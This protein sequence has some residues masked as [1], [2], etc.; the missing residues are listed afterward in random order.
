M[1]EIMAFENDS[2]LKHCQYK[3]R[4]KDF[5]PNLNGCITHYRSNILGS[6]KEFEL[7]ASKRSQI[8]FQ[9]AIEM[10]T[11]ELKFTYLI[12]KFKVCYRHKII[13]NKQFELDTG[14]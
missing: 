2:F 6:N 3:K 13:N 9:S 5:A 12:D 11:I 7:A 1:V 8:P 4:E 14:V 10:G